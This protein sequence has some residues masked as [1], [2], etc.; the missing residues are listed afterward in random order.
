MITSAVKHKSMGKVQGMV[1]M[2][3]NEC[4][5]QGVMSTGMS[6]RISQGTMGMGNMSNM[7]MSNVDSS[8]LAIKRTPG[9]RPPPVPGRFS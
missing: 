5:S 1:S 7:D 6:V 4:V 3:V 8:T 2:G 9:G